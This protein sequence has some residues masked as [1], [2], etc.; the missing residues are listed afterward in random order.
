MYLGK[1]RRPKGDSWKTQHAKAHFS[2]VIKKAICEGDQ[3]IKHRGEVVVI[4]SKSRYEELMSPSH[5][6][7]DFFYSVPDEVVD[8]EIKRSLDL[9]R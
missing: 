8:L 6:L 4:L 1:K 5:S 2:E 9:P 7:L 3:F